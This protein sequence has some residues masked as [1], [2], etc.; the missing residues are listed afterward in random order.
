M[1][2][3]L[4]WEIYIVTIAFITIIKCILTSEFSYFYGYTKGS[5]LPMYSQI[6]FVVRLYT[7]DGTSNLFYCRL[8]I[9]IVVVKMNQ[10][11]SLPAKC[12]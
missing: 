8:K 9:P 12:Q 1:H 2:T 3:L 4:C 6:Y 10:F 7:V 5:L 11:P